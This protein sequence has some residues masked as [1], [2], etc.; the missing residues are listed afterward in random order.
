V[1]RDV[2][3]IDAFTGGLA[4]TAPTDGLVGPTFACIIGKQF[5][6]LKFGDRFFF[7]NDPGNNDNSR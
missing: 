6:F 4:E 5:Q 3:D 7:N 1:Y 2:D